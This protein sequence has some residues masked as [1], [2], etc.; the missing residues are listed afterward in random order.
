MCDHDETCLGGSSGAAL[1]PDWAL[2]LWLA[3]GPRR[4]IQNPR[5]T[6]SKGIDRCGTATI[7]ARDLPWSIHFEK[8]LERLYTDELRSRGYHPRP[9]TSVAELGRLF[10]DWRRRRLEHLVGRNLRVRYSREI[11][12]QPQY[13]AVKAIAER[14]RKGQPLHPYTSKNTKKGRHNDELLNHWGIFH[15]HLGGE[16]ESDDGFVTRDQPLVYVRP[17]NGFFY[18]L[19]VFNH[20]FADSTLLEIVVR[21]WPESVEKYR[22]RGIKVQGRLPAPT[23]FSADKMKTFDR[24]ILLHPAQGLSTT[25][26]N[27]LRNQGLCPTFEAENG[28]QYFAPGGGYSCS[29]VGALPIVHADHEWY[30]VHHLANVV[31]TAVLQ[32]A[33]E[34]WQRAKSKPAHLEFHVRSFE[35]IKEAMFVEMGSGLGFKLQLSHQFDHEFDPATMMTTMAA[36]SM[37]RHVQFVV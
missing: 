25:E 34:V 24:G 28:D 19:G 32:I 26:V 29:G 17:D 20:V 10:H 35:E 18:V 27:Q 7:R 30:W 12:K 6:L 33:E 2:V 16:A 4:A 31:E 23:I 14:S 1:D 13:P 9:G 8:D 5:M 37:Y 3:L 36:A 15:L 11:A 21:N 22:F